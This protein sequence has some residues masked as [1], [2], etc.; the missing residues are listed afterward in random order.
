MRL[1]T[2]SVQ[3]PS[4]GACHADTDHDGDSF[5]CDPCGLDYSDGQDG[6]EATYRD[7]DAAPCAKPC[8]NT[9]HGSRDLGPYDCRSCAL[10]SGHESDCWTNCTPIPAPKTGATP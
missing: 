8:T 4:C 6:T 10:P 7:E 9:W 2:C 3:Y 5:Y 1:P